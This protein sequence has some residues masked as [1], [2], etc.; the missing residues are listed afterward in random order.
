MTDHDP[1]CCGI[2][3]ELDCPQC[4][5][6][7]PPPPPPSPVDAARRRWR[8]LESRYRCL[9]D[10]DARAWDW[11]E[12][13]SPAELRRLIWSL[14]DPTQRAALREVLLDL[15]AEPIGQLLADARREGAG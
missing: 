15:F 2:Y 10:R 1:L 9:R 5:A 4:Q 13:L 6:A 14:L 12:P 3:P 8:E 11:P 7:A